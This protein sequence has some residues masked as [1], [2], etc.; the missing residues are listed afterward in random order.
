MS[1]PWENDGCEAVQAYF[2]IYPVP[3]A[4]A[5]WCQIPAAEVQEQLSAATETSQPA[6]WRHPYIP[7]LEPRC[8]AI[9]DAINKGVLACSRENGHITQEHVKPERRHV[10][11]QHLKEW[12]AKEFPSDKPAFLFDEVERKTHS[13][14]NAESF[15]ALQADR[16]ALNAEL[17]NEKEK[18]Q[19]LRLEK[20][21]LE[22]ENES[23]RTMVEKFSKSRRDDLPE[24]ERESLLKMVL[25]MA[26]SSYQYELG[27]KKNTATGDNKGSIPFDLSKLGLNLNCD[28]VRKFIKEAEGRCFDRLPKP[29][30]S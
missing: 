10:S 2:T 6:V 5:L 17:I 14:I 30:N 25:G 3:V 1:K 12:I 29:D 9:H 4:A 16:A 23:L 24:S 26:I 7:C 22:V 13:A 8:R 15:R 19:N 21:D 28:T 27:S 20:N 18:H 11:R